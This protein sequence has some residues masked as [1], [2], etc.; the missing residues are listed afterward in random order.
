MYKILVLISTIVVCSL[1]AFTPATTTLQLSTDADKD[2]TKAPKLNLVSNYIVT[3]GGCDGFSGSTAKVMDIEK[4]IGKNL[5][6]KDPKTNASYNV[7][8]FDITYC[9][10][11]V[12]EDSLGMPIVGVDCNSE[13]IEGCFVPDKWIRALKERLYENDTLKFTNMY[14]QSGAKK[15]KAKNEIVIIVQR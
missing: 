9:E 7:S 15:Y 5:C 11:T 2:S 8:R 6:A 3:I 4:Y 1:M 10:R 14:V 13:T 12:A